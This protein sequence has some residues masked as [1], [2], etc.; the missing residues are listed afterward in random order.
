MHSVIL[1]LPHK[2][3]RLPGTMLRHRRPGPGHPGAVP[4]RQ[5]LHRAVRV[6]PVF[7]RDHRPIAH[8][9]VPAVGILLRRDGL[10]HGR[11]GDLQHRGRE[12]PVRRGLYAGV[13]TKERSVADA[14]RR[15]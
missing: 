6:H 7:V 1:H 8:V 3:M 2:G 12:H 9:H 11:W 13:H 4:V 15:W 5:M 14:R 10:Q